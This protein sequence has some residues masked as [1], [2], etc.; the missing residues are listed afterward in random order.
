[1]SLV[2][3][4]AAICELLDWIDHAVISTDDEEIAAEARA[5]GLDAPFLRPSE[6]SGDEALTINAWRHALL[7]S[8]DH[9]AM[10][11]DVTLLLEPTSPL[12]RPEDVTR[13]V[14]IVAEERQPAAATV[15]KTPGSFTPHKTLTMSKDGHLGFYLEGGAHY[16]IRQRI[17][18]YYHRN[19]ICYATTR[20][21]LLDADNQHIIEDNCIGVV[22]DR[23]LV[24]IDD[25]FELELAEWM[26][27]RERA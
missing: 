26:L 14:A 9:Y 17:P 20:E 6:L 21:A 5:H 24:N 19:G 23:P 22:I 16:S 4:A 1:M 8:E 18:Q 13:T 3:R 12:R 10:T 25:P 11:F 7:S 2:A 15:S 27:S